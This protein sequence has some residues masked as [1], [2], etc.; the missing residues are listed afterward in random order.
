MV[1]DYAAMLWSSYNFWCKR[2]YDGL[3]CGYS[4]WTD[5]TY[6]VRSPELFHELIQA[7]ANGTQ[8]V[9]QPFY[10][11]MQYPCVNAGGYYSEYLQN[12]LFRRGLRNY[13][14]VIATEELDAYP[15]HVAQRIAYILN[16]SI[17]GI[18]LSM[19][20]RV[21]INSQE[22]KGA[23]HSIPIEKYIPGRYEISKYQP[24]LQETRSLLY[25]CW[26]EDCFLLANITRYR[27]KA[28]FPEDFNNKHYNYND[29]NNYGADNY[30]HKLK[31]NYFH[32][33]SGSQ[34]GKYRY[35]IG[36]AIPWDTYNSN[37]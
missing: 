7:D 24:M 5:P 23:N 12:H 18:D 29:S 32:N 19:F 34:F 26:R 20:H 31:N 22:D 8:G 30:I 35:A 4:K 37:E 15:L 16:Y 33:S 25:K 1:R 36:V 27:Y 13:T 9:I 10:Y 3:N 28:C 14:I 17:V 2:E 6:H 11:P 21:R